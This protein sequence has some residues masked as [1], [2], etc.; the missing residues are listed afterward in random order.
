MQ[1]T[2]TRVAASVA[3]ALGMLVSTNSGAV[4]PEMLETAPD[5]TTLAPPDLSNT[6]VTVVLQLAGNSIAE[7]QGAAGRK[8]DRA[9]KDGIK[10]QLRAQQEALRP[11]IESA[12]GVVLATF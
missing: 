2:S 12:G 11:S 5:F 9:E 3:L 1:V 7:Q 10:A 8:L 6:P 4:L